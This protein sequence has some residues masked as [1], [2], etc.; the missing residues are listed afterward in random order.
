MAYIIGFNEVANPLLTIVPIFLMVLSGYTIGTIISKVRRVNPVSLRDSIYGSVALNFLFILGFIIF[1]LINEVTDYFTAFTYILVGLSILGIYLLSKKLIVTSPSDDIGVFG[2]KTSNDIKKV[3]SLLLF[4]YHDNNSQ[5]I[6]FGIALFVSVLVYQAIIIY[7][8]PIYSEYD[9]IFKFLPISKSIL[10]GNGLNHD[11]YLGSDVNMRY[12]PYTQAVNAWLIHSFEYSSVRMFPFYFVFFAAI[13]VYSITRNILMKNSS[14]GEALFFGLIASSAFLVT[15]ALLVVSSRFSLQQ[16]LAFIFF[17]TA[18]FYTLSE[19]VRYHKPAK[20]NLLILSMSLAL[21]VLTREIGLVISLAIFFL[22]PAIKYTEGNLKLRALFTILSF[23]PLYTLS[24]KDFFEFGLTYTIIIRLF[25]LLLLNFA[26]FYIVSQLK[27]QNKFSSLIRPLSNFRYLLPLVIP[28]IFIMTNM[29]AFGGPFPTFTFSDKLSELLPT[30]R[31]ISGIRD[32][33]YLDLWQALQNLPRLDILFISVAMGSIFIFFKLLGLG[34]IIYDL[35]N[36]Y[37]YSLLLILLI[38]LLV[39]WSFLLQSDFETSDI[40]HVAYFIPLLSI[41]LVF[42]M[43]RGRVS[44]T[45][46]KIFYYGVI[47]FATYCFLS[48]N[49]FIWNYNGH[50]GGFWIEPNKGSFITLDDLM[51]V[52]AVMGGLIILELGGQKFSPLI[53][54]N[55]LQ[56]YS[57][58]VFILLFSV[59]LYFLFNSGIMVAPL[60][61]MDQAPPKEWETGLF[62]VLDYLNGAEN[63]NVLAV[64]APAIPFFTNRTDFDLLYPQSFAYAISPLLLTENS[65]LFKQKLSDMGI[66]YIVIPNVGNS[67]YYLVQNLMKQSK[68]VQIINTDD[69]FQR[70]TLKS[71]SIYKFIPASQRINLVDDDHIWKPRKNITIS[72]HE[73]N[74]NITVITNK[75]DKVEKNLALLKTRLNLTERPL[76]LSLSYASKSSL[77][78]TTFKVEIWHRSE[79]KKLFSSLLN[80]TS[81]NLINQTLILPKSTAGNQPLEFRLYFITKDPGE[82]A[83][84]LKRIQIAYS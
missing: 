1:A 11:F 49:L 39:T 67:H 37:Q 80:N 30:Y 16:D 14:K 22:V 58:L 20:S 44:S 60:E 9:S 75:K 51:V 64:R 59:Q 47:V 33:L 81:G 72:Q 53:K 68:L 15:P 25:T 70:I 48:L 84:N 13:V 26:I 74:L 46:C 83:L 21:M 27:Y 77:E 78:T 69:D 65:S 2:V 82:H 28:L 41:I 8:H 18:A 32:P 35:K 23:L 66:K 4:L 54:R 3:K 7:Y 17:L 43:V 10:L 38:F 12:P 45:Y 19:I 55:N 56:R 57:S 62:E 24:F 50:F 42:G 34:R 76:L 79:D 5:I 40:R 29:I 63:G 71:F 52:A 61:N 6:L 31:E 73:G 36:N